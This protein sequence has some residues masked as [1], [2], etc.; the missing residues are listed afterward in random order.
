MARR[1]DSTW[2]RSVVSSVVRDATSSRAAPPSAPSR[3]DVE[4][5]IVAF[6]REVIRP[7]KWRVRVPGT[8]TGGITH[9]ELFDV[10]ASQGREFFSNTVQL[11][12]AVSA[13][14]RRE[15][16]SPLPA[17]LPTLDR[18]RKTAEPALLGHVERRLERGNGDIKPTQLTPRYAAR[19]RALGRGSQ[20]IGVAS[21]EL[22]RA[23]SRG[24]YVEWT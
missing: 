3:R 15:Y 23:L 24:A 20:P 4:S 2:P 14:L 7:G 9:E 12:L 22:R 17:K 18:L 21:G 13:A 1:D 11:A 6:T 16:L 19:K 8:H 5:L 10:L